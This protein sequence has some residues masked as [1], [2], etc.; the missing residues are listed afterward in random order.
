MHQN[1][2]EIQIFGVTVWNGIIF[3]LNRKNWRKR[4][5]NCNGFILGVINESTPKQMR[6][7]KVTQREKGLEGREGTGLKK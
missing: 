2:I 1:T 5:G 3:L 7:G 6:E 4:K